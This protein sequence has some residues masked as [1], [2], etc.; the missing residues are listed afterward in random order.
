MIIPEKDRQVRSFKIPR[1][2]FRSLTFSAVALA[3]LLGILSYDYIK[4]LKQVYA[5][6]QLN[7]ENRQLREQIQLFQMK[8]NSLAGDID[9]I[10]TFEKKMRVIT[11]LEDATTAPALVPDNDKEK[12]EEVFLENKST[13]INF[14]SMK[15]D[16]LYLE[17][18]EL[19]DQKVASKLGL[20]T[21]L[22]IARNWS[23]VGRRSHA[24]AED[25]AAFDFKY[26]RVKTAMSDLEIKVNELD[27]GLL[28]RESILSSTPTLLPSTG[29]I[30]SYFGHRISPYSNRGA[31]KMHEGLDVGAP[32]GTPIIAPADGLVVF[33]GNKFTFGKFVQIDHGYG[34]ETAYAHAQKLY[35]KTGQKVKRGDLLARVGSTGNSTGPH[36]HYEVRVNGVPVDPLYF[37]LEM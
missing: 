4:I 6:K 25:F 22:E 26:R 12:K 31:I 27:E 37:V 15:T 9:R 29:W 14:E 18:K 34:I 20:R 21:N 11:G 35:V 24:L 30:T 19:Y 1:I 5:N 32:Y 10:K 3:I 36:L 16:P 2:L 13:D 7:L 33:S 23:E 28:D 17:L 8:I